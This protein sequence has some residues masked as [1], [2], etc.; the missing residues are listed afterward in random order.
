M[1]NTDEAEFW[2]GAAGQKWIAHEF[3][4]DRLLGAV[5]DALIGTA[6]P[7][8]GDRV[9]DIGCGTGAVTMLAAERVGTDG[10]VL[11]TDIAPPFVARVTERSE[12]LP[13]VR[14]LLADAQSAVW[15]ETGFDLAV[16][17]LGVMFFDDPPKAFG[18]IAQALKPGGTMVFAAWATV[19]ENP[20]WSVPREMIERRF[21]P[22]PR[23]GPN[24]PGPMG[25]A[26]TG[27]TL[28]QFRKAGLE[29]GVETRTV[30]LI[31]DGGAA[32][33]ADLM[34]RIGPAARALAEAGATTEQI[35]GFASEAARLL[36]RYETGGQARIP[37]TVHIYKARRD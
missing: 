15:P 8:P 12:N 26:D 6:D 33:A 16:S 28:E 5:A 32:G 9:L 35:A 20:Y 21:G 3:E 10:L 25:L 36:N 13:Q 30:P 7:S 23:P 22:R 27:W 24:A 1:S 4:Q 19:E 34:L 11:A 14:T 17:R 31:H 29:A 2:S 18:N 37:G